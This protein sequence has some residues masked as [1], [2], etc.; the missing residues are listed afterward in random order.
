MIGLVLVFLLELLVERL[1]A[2]LRRVGG[3]ADV[4]DRAV[5]RVA[6][7]LDHL[8]TRQRGL[9]DDRLV[10]ALLLQLAQ[11][12]RRLLLVGVDE[13]RVRVRLLGLEH[14]AGEVELP[15]SVEMSATTLM[16]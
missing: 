13:E 4:R 2:G 14:G 1:D 15:G 11:R 12:T 16:P 5:G 6:R 9:A 10:V 7:E 3:E 8:L